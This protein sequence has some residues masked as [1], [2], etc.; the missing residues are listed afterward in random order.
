MVGTIISQPGITVSSPGV[1]A[2]ISTINGRVIAL[3]YLNHRGEHRHQRPGG[4]MP[5]TA[6]HKAVSVC[7]VQGTA[8]FGFRVELTRRSVFDDRDAQFE[9][10]TMKLSASVIAIAA[11][12]CFPG[13][14]VRPPLGGNCKHVSQ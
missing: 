12:E 6:L 13:V 1:R 2:T 8:V 10:P 3:Q 14:R 11:S 7:V 4:A 9:R 5:E